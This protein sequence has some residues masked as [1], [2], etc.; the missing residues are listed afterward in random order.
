LAFSSNL[1]RPASSLSFTN[2]FVSALSL[3]P[4]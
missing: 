3:C 4:F 1:T 2:D